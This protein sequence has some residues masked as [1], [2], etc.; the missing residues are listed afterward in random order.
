[1]MDEVK[2]MT[3]DDFARTAQ[4]KSFGCTEPEF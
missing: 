2:V 1:M 3:K 4:A